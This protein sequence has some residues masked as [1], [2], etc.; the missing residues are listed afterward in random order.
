MSEEKNGDVS[1]RKVDIDPNKRNIKRKLSMI[2]SFASSLASRSFNNKKINEPIKQLRVLSCFGNQN[3]GGILP[4]CEHLMDSDTG[5]GKHYCGACG[6]GDRKGT[7]LIQEAD[8][9][10]KLDYPKVS[11]P[12]QMPGFTNYMLSTPDESE[13]PVTRKYY[14]ENIEYE[15]VKKVPVKIGDIPPKPKE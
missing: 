1:F 6:C 3:V 15:Q 7:W 8:E 2:Q 12:L 4:R 5:E 11:C 14:I 10:S 9:Y 13:E